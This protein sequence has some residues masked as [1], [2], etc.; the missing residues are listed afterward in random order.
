MGICDNCGKDRKVYIVGVCVVKGEK[1]QICCCRYCRSEE[2][3]RKIKAEKEAVK[4]E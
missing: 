3:T 4:D 1:E 2:I